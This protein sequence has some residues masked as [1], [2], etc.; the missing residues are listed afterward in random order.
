MAFIYFKIKKTMNGISLF[1]GIGGIDVALSPWVRTVFYCEI[2]PYCQS[3]LLQRMQEGH[4]SKA[5]IW[6][7]IRTFPIRANC[8][9]LPIDIIFGGFPCQDISVAGLGNGLAGERSGLFYEIM[10]QQEEKDEIRRQLIE[11]CD[12]Q[13]SK[14]NGIKLIKTVSKGKVMYDTVPQLVGVD[15]DKH[16]ADP[17]TSWRVYVE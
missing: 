11:L 2:D 4:L 1:S 3:V 6:T 9:M 7:D 8:D 12:S 5:P 13:S 14:G 16:R 15:L 10:R 17:I